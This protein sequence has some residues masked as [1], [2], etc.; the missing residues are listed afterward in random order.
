MH[1]E[2]ISGAS[3]D[4]AILRKNGIAGTG[5]VL[6]DLCQR[7]VRLHRLSPLVLSSGSAVGLQPSNSARHKVSLLSVRRRRR[8]MQK[9]DIT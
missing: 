3:V 6:K 8:N 5:R 9:I 7:N 1:A 2:F 4:S